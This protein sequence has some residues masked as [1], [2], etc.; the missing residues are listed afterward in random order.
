MTGI[1]FICY[2][3]N[4]IHYLL[5]AYYT[6]FGLVIANIFFYHYTIYDLR[7]GM[8]DYNPANHSHK[9]L[10]QVKIKL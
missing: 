4:N 7:K 3:N 1:I 10:F 2:N 8:I 9:I 5:E 6:L